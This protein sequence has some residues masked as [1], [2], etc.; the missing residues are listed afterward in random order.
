MEEGWLPQVREPETATDRPEVRCGEALAVREAALERR[1]ERQ[2]RLAHLAQEE[3]Q[4]DTRG[5]SAPGTVV[6]V[7]PGVWCLADIAMEE[8]AAAPP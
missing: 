8:H 2:E 4:V 3:V 5:P 7:R 6:E 1:R